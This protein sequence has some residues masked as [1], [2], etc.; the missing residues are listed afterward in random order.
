M[1]A[2]VLKTV[3]YKEEKLLFVG[4]YPVNK[5]LD[6]SA[7]FPTEIKLFVVESVPTT[8]PDA[9]VYNLLDTFVGKLGKN[10]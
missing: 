5:K 4:C 1:I 2:Y 9:R 7:G 6:F 8:S 3:L 10:C